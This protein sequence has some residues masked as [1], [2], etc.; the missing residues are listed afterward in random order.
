ME[1]ER[2][3]LT[4]PAAGHSLCACW[5]YTPEPIPQEGEAKRKP[6]RRD[7]GRGA[8]A[9]TAYTPELWRSREKERKNT[10]STQGREGL[11]KG[12][13]GMAGHR[14]QVKGTSRVEFERVDGGLECQREQ[15]SFERQEEEI[16]CIV[17]GS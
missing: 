12:T 9:L 15:E 4:A 6:S 16:T 3:H 5:N 2:A 10:V 11:R 8:V 17:V 14:R 13:C 1:G 7:K